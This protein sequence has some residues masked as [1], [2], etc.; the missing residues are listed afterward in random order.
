VIAVKRLPITG[1]SLATPER[2]EEELA[3][4]LSSLGLNCDSKRVQQIYQKLK[5]II[6]RWWQ[7]QESMET[8]S[9]A[10]ALLSLRRHLDEVSVSLSGHRTGFRELAQIHVVS[11]LKLSLA[12]DPKVGGLEEAD[13]FLQRFVDDADKIAVQCAS[14][15]AELTSEKGPRGRPGPA[16]VQ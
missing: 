8:G 7:E 13:R 9:V 1:S 2:N 6:G 5:S 15:Y 14:A 3:K 12:K 4:Y 10:N 11:Q 16:V